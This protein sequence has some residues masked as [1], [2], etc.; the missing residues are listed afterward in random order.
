VHSSVY[1]LQNIDALFFILGWASCGSHKKHTRQIMS[2]LCFLHLVRFVGHLVHFGAFGRKTSM[3]YF[4][5][6]CG[7]GVDPIK[8]ATGHVLS[9]LCFC[10]WCDL[11]I[12]YCGLVCPG[13]ETL[14]HY[15]S[16]L[17]RPTTVLL[18]SASGHVMLNLCFCI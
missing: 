12:T 3:H 17:A 13:N 11:W 7:P 1:R 4:S 6:S 16:C 8:S 2:N 9:N 18:K 5:C 15:L 10:I 14:T